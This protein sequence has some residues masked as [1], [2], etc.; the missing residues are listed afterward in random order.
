MH[1]QTGESKLMD[2]LKATVQQKS[3]PKRTKEKR[4]EPTRERLLKIQI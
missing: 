2:V 1:L 4:F 3:Y